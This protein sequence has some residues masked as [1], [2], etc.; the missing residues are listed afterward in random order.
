LFEA[1]SRT[2][3]PSNGPSS[4]LSN[5]TSASDSPSAPFSNQPSHNPS[6]I[7][8]EAPSKTQY[9]YNGPSSNQSNSPSASGSL[10]AL[11]SN[12]PSHNPSVIPSEAPSKLNLH[13]TDLAVIRAT[14]HLPVGVQVHFLPINLAITQVY[15][16]RGTKQNSISAVTDLAVIQATLRSRQSKQLSICQ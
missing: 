2:P 12:Q 14:L 7:P 15:S 13:P 10:S 16:V 1:P 5:F 6:V 4:N 11:S 9:P 8:S 3:S